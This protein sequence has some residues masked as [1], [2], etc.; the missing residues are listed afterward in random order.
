M[1]VQ[2]PG[3]AGPNIV[4]KVKDTPEGKFNLNPKARNLKVPSWTGQTGSDTITNAGQNG[5]EGI[6]LNKG[7]YLS[8]LDD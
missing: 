2:R 5:G 6:V 4:L 7:A 3:N 1:A 8:D